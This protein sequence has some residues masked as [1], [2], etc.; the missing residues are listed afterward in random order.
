[1]ATEFWVEIIKAVGA[2][3]GPVLGYL[4]STLRN[5][6]KRNYLV[7]F[8]IQEQ[9]KAILNEGR[10]T[11]RV[12]V[13]ETLV[14]YLGS[15]RRQQA[16][17]NETVSRLDTRLSDAIGRLEQQNLLNREERQAVS[18][19]IVTLQKTIQRKIEVDE[20]LK[21]AVDDLRKVLS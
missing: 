10:E 13:V 1:M 2:V 21:Q 4:L 16:D 12:V 6:R 19:R 17:V 8:T 18:D 15:I 5:Q 9:V 11:L 7:A 20:E 3:A 14:Q